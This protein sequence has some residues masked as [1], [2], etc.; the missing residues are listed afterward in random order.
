VVGW[1]LAAL[2]G[3]KPFPVLVLQ[4]EQGAGKST[5]S[6]VIRAL[7]DP[8][9]APLRS[10][11][12]EVR[13]LLVSAA[14]SHVMALDNL[15]GLNP[16]LSDALCRLST[17]GAIDVRQLYTDLEQVL[18][19]L[20]RPVICNGIDDIATRPDLA[21]RS[22]VIN[23]KEIS[24]H[25]RISETEFWDLFGIDRPIIFAALL[26]GLVTALQ[27][28]QVVQMKRLP[29]M[30]DF[31]LWVTAAEA[32]FGWDG[33]FMAAYSQNQQEAVEAGIE[34]SP[35]GPAIMALMAGRNGWSGKPTELLAALTDIA[36]KQVARSKDWPQST[37]GLKNILTR[38][39]P[40][41][42][43]AGIE[44]ETRRTSSARYYEIT[45]V[46]IDTSHTSQ[47]SRFDNHA[48]FRVTESVT[49]SEA[50]ENASQSETG[51]YVGFDA[52]SDHDGC[53]ASASD[54][55]QSNRGGIKL[56]D[57][58]VEVF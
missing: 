58:N 41:L 44:W 32:A 2:G 43:K 17:G 12:R 8:S 11:P 40:S 6:R 51:D 14:N 4:G 50:Y 31:A 15:S 33:D 45:K 22:L 47:T 9:T 1:L 53:P 49:D 35:V 7:V 30:A 5:A 18:V 3:A 42:R 36:G 24:D 38:L 23:L 21:Q 25:E 26:D 13:D 10:P 56:N 34:A 52:N 54:S 16:E 39:G 57:Q 29:R 37:K 55:S 48:S 19:E 20:Q 28:R 46:P 27:R